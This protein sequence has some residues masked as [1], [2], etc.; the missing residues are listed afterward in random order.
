MG[1][2]EEGQRAMERVLCVIMDGVGLRSSR[3]GNA[4]ALARKPHLDQ[5]AA[6]SL[7][8]TLKAHGTAVGLPSDDDIGNSE[9]GHNALGAGRIFA[10]GAKLVQRAL[11]TGALFQG[12]GWRQVV[13]AA[14]A[15]GRS[16]HFIGLLSDG[17]VHAHEDHLY[18]MLRQAK[19]EGVRR[20]RIH[21]L[22]DGRDVGERSAETYVGRLEQVM[23][24]LRG[25]DCDVQVASGGGRMH[26]TMDRY[27]A[28]WGMV[29][30]G[31]DAHVL[32]RAEWQFPSL[33]AAL[34]EFRKDPRLTDQYLPSFVVVSDGK[35]V[36]TIESGDAVVLAN[37]RGDRAIEISRALTE[38]AFAEFDRVRVP[39]VVFAGMM[40]Y[41]GDLH[42]PPLYLVSPPQI[43]RT[44]TEYLVKH[45]ARQFACSETQK[46]GHVTYFW[47]G[48]R[49]GYV[50]PALE[51]YVEIPSDSDVTFDK[52]PAMKAAGIADATIERMRQR[53][54]DFGR[55]NFANGDMVGHT[56]SL[57][58]AVRSVEAL[59]EAIGRLVAAAD[60]TGTTLIVLADHG[61]VEEMFDADEKN[62]PDWETKG[63]ATPPRPKTAHTR[64]PVPCYIYGRAARG[65]RL[66]DVS[67]RLLGNVANT[68]LDLMGLP[69][70][71]DYLPSLVERE[72]G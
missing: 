44:L 66:A 33:P 55:I 2:T 57:E 41:D 49:S 60:E 54:F 9:V 5:L 29:K 26:I 20:L 72:R 11:E 22:F 43:D 46:F 15:E 37:F 40:E 35:P 51:E 52:R 28:D 25:P 17:N 34:A 56:G 18:E 19:R 63:F 39:S 48:N 21:V 70:S 31:W 16:L 59:D 24:E 61:N 45:K 30:R 38:R 12:T 13:S 32:G 68:V 62:Y 8:T 58:A 14:K 27:N 50:A 67:Q 71:P 3:F 65:F 6:R 10:Q 69:R 36:G 7:A 23:A 64:N 1:H 42:I 4:Y 53:S 47:N